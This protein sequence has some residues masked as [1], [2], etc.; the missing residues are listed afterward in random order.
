MLDEFFAEVSSIERTLH[1]SYDPSAHRFVRRPGDDAEVGRALGRLPTLYPSWVDRIEEYDERRYGPLLGV[2]D[3]GSACPLIADAARASAKARALGVP[4]PAAVGVIID[5]ERM[6]SA[7]EVPI[8]PDEYAAVVAAAFGRT[9]CST[10]V[11]VRANARL[12]LPLPEVSLPE[13][14]A[15]VRPAIERVLALFKP[16]VETPDGDP[17][18]LAVRLRVPPGAP[19]DLVRDFVQ[20]VEA[21]RQVGRLAG[22]ASIH[23][24]SLLLVF[25]NEIGSAGDVQ[26]V[27]ALL[28]L[29]GELGVAEVALD[30]EL[31]EGARRR[32]SV[33]GLLNILRPQELGPLL[34]IAREAGVRLVPRYQLDAESA[35]RTIWTG[36]HCARSYGLNAGKYGLLPLTLEEQEMVARQIARWTEGWTA[37]PAFYVDTPL[38]SATDVYDEARCAEAAALWMERMCDAGA[39]VLLFDSPDR[40]EP[41]RLLKESAAPGDRGVLT[42]DDVV[43]LTRRGAKLGLK[44][45]WSGGITPRQAYELARLG[46][47][48]IFTTSS[49][50]RRIRVGAVLVNDPQLAAE[51]EPT[52]LGVR[53]VHAL[54][55]GG[56]LAGALAGTEAGAAVEAGCGRLLEAVAAGSGVEA[57]LDALEA[58]L[59]EGWRGHWRTLDGGE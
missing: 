16:F 42:L 37:I 54:I 36:L 45:L 43:R 1:E 30:A 18:P 12:Y 19:A 58:P 33:Q 48:G 57:A 46:V 20:A 55:Q 38:V 7:G 34:A 53:R 59:T 49:T 27:A 50:A 22:D 17:R 28:R 29:A 10:N 24:L 51:N 13:D 6:T 26:S 3:E 23:R 15:E 8:G 35:A 11:G 9:H 52:E 40:V 14:A 4:D 21:G 32:L 25:E 5:G 44:L 47:G 31:L 41:R 2:S 56:Y 39:R